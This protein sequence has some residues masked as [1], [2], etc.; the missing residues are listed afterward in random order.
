MILMMMGQRHLQYPCDAVE[1]VVDHQAIHPLSP[2]KSWAINSY[3]LVGGENVLIVWSPLGIFPV[4]IGVI[5]IE[6]LTLW[7]S[8]GIVVP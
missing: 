2:Q 7:R 5:L 6:I 1:G 8:P 4:K 3:V